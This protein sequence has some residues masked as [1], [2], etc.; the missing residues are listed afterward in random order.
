MLWYKQEEEAFSK[1]DLEND[2]TESDPW[3]SYMRYVNWQLVFPLILSHRDS[4]EILILGPGSGKE[5]EEFSK[6]YPTWTFH[7]IEPSSP[8]RVLLQN[9]FPTSRIYKPDATN[10]MQLKNEQVDVVLAFSVLHHI[11]NVT[12]V[13]SEVGRVL[14][15]GGLFITREPCSSMGDWRKERSTTPN[16]R[17]IAKRFMISSAKKANLFLSYCEPIPILFE[18]INKFLKK[19]G[20]DGKIAFSIVYFVDRIISRIVSVNDRYWRNT[21][22][23]KIGPSSYIYYFRRG[24]GFKSEQEVQ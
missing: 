24:E 6:R 21:F 18:P 9:R 8:F 3:Y 16:E 20:L 4:G 5:I 15:A 19:I 1:S 23:K 11:A 17:G 13:L 2:M 22:F 7:F 14:K 12:Y 10:K